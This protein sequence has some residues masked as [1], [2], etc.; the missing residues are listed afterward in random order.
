MS[1]SFILGNLLGRAAVTYLLIWL[2]WFCFT[3]FDWRK[4]FMRSK[5]WYSLV[6]LVL[7][8]LGGMGTAVVHGGGFA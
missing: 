7:F 4:A 8:T 3:R 2:V 1:I 5:R 6:A